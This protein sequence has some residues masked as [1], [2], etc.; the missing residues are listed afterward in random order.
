MKLTNLEMLNYLEALNQISEK[1]YGKLGYAVARNLRKIAN[2]LVEFEQIRSDTFYKYATLNENDEYELKS[3]TKPY[4]DFM[5]E[6][7]EI[8]SIRHKVDIYKIE[9][10]VVIQSGLNAKELNSLVF[11]IK[12]EGEE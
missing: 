9:P 7:H 5:D 12:D 6:M 10:D 1:V 2:E 8:A 3:N 4:K 11:M